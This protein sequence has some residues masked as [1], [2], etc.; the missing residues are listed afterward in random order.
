MFS[1]CTSTLI[2]LY[3]GRGGGT[4]IESPRLLAT[5]SMARIVPLESGHP[6]SKAKIELCGGQ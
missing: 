6:S 3:A 4:Q 5:T 2:V 1:A